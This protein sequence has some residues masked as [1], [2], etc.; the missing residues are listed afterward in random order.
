MCNKSKDG[1]MCVDFNENLQQCTFRGAFFLQHWRIISID[2]TSASNNFNKSSNIF[3]LI[4]FFFKFSLILEYPYFLHMEQGFNERIWERK[5]MR[6]TIG[7]I[8]VNNII[9]IGLK[10]KNSE[11][12]QKIF[13]FFSISKES[14]E[15]FSTNNESKI[16]RKKKLL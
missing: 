4:L 13:I 1:G 10:K 14:V 3:V 11:G 2:Q 16:W 8:N 15:Y 9:M 5:R 12:K 6:N 7:T